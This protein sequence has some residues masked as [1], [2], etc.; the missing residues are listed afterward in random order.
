ML[1]IYSPTLYKLCKHFGS[2]SLSWKSASCLMRLSAAGW[3]GNILQCL[4]FLVVV[5]HFILR[6]GQNRD[7]HTFEKKKKKNSQ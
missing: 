6:P 3:A 4:G 2:T 5:W 1:C 7:E